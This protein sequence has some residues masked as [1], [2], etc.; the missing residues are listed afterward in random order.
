M[1]D[2]CAWCCAEIDRE[3]SMSD[4]CADCDVVELKHLEAE[5]DNEFRRW[6]EI[7]NRIDIARGK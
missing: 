1:T 2:K 4:L 6:R 5:Q 3:K 7:D